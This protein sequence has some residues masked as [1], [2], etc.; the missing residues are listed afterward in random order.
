MDVPALAP[1]PGQGPAVAAGATP[2]PAATAPLVG[3]DLSLAATGIA[4]WD[5][6]HLTTTTVGSKGKRGDNYN[7]RGVRLVD[8]R[9]RI[10]LEI[11][12]RALVVIEGPAYSA[13]ADPSYFDRAGLW[14]LLVTALQ[15]RRHDVAVVTTSGLKKYATGK[16]NSGKDEVLAA[17][18]KR[19]PMVD[20]TDNNV[21]DAVTLAAM[22]LDFYGTPLVEMPAGHRVA[23]DAVE[24][25]AAKAAA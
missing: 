16:G 11:P 19:F 12:D 9:S 3:V 1:R 18:V 7:A 22:A 10:L 2:L 25:P 20:V 15:S 21:A 8:L 4:R 6:A 17:V 23:L 5:G 24:W 14:W 13:G